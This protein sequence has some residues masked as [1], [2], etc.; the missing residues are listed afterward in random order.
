MAN[1]F[2][3]FDAQPSSQSSGN[4]FDQFD[5][6]KANPFDQFDQSAV[7]YGTADSAPDFG[8]NGGSE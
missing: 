2:D 6:P 3:Q 4:P 5:A 7:G 8:S 1:P